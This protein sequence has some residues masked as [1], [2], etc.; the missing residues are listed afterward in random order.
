MIRVL[1][2]GAGVQSSTLALMIAKGEVPMVDAAIFADTQAE[3]KAV[4]D[5]LDWLEKQLP[6]PVHRVTAGSL[7]DEVM[8]PNRGFNP[9]PAFKGGAIGRRQCTWQF[10]LRPLHKKMRELAGLAKGERSKGVAVAS[11]MGISHDEVYRMKSSN[12]AWLKI[13]WPLVDLRMT[14][15]HCIEWMTANEYPTPPRS[16]CVFCPYKSDAE[17]QH[18]KNTDQAGWEV[19][20]KVDTILG[21]RGERLHRTEKP[22]ADV[23]LTDTRRDLFNNECEGMCGV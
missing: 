10:K 3:P 20:V 22:L 23:Q 8:N 11:L 6:F 4:Y 12:F 9:I 7:L 18:T 13:E 2:L 15:G 19:A 16:A 1:S 5:W 14:R 21:V 17:W